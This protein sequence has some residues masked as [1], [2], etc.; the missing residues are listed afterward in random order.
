M[1]KKI[2]ISLM[3]CSVTSLAD[4][5]TSSVSY[6]KKSIN[7]STSIVKLSIP[8]DTLLYTCVQPDTYIK[9]IKTGKELD[10]KTRELNLCYE[11]ISNYTRID[12]LHK[13]NINSCNENLNELKSF[14]DGIT[15][16][17]RDASIKLQEQREERLYWVIGAFAA[18]ALV[19]ALNV[20]LVK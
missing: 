4:T 5:D 16:Q 8:E 1:L 17:L 10:L 11:N 20:Y 9:I 7:D 13:I 15:K 19:T 2:M 12:S 6:T 14:N 18:G 3:I